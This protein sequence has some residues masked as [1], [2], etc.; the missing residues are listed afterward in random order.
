[1][2]N[3][4]VTRRLVPEFREIAEAGLGLFLGFC[5][6]GATALSGAGILSGASVF[7]GGCRHIGL[8]LFGTVCGAAALSGTGILSGAR[9]LFGLSGGIALRASLRCAVRRR[10]G[11]GHR[12]SEQT[13]ERRS[14]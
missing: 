8:V 6:G 14:Y 3:R 7:F 9:M 11:S 13:G 5:V 12:T 1:M 2:R 4:G 10:V